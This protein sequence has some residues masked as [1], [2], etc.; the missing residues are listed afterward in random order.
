MFIII[1]KIYDLRG[2]LWLFQ[3]GQEGRGYAV[4]KAGGPSH[5]F[6]TQT[7][8]QLPDPECNFP[9][10]LSVMEPLQSSVLAS[11]ADWQPFS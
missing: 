8:S 3:N 1:A 7:V 4:P 6:S 5:F 11:I 2:I 10:T 9:A